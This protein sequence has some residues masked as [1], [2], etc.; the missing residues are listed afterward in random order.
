[1]ITKKTDER[2]AF[3]ITRQVRLVPKFVEGYT[4][5]YFVHF[6]RTAV[7]MGCPKKCWAMLLQTVFTGKAQRVHATLSPEEFSEYKVVKKAVLKKLSTS[8]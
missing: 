5:E 1:M 2:L 3:D 7:N 6:E 8:A 4:D